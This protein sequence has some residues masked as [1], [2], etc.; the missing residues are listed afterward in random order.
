[1]RTISTAQA[2]ERFGELVDEL[3]IG[4]P[5]GVED[6]GSFFIEE[7]GKPVGL[8]VARESIVQLFQQQEEWMRNA[9]A[10]G[11]AALAAGDYVELKS[12][13][14]VHAFFEDIKRRGRERL[15]QEKQACRS[16]AE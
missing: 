1:M 13:E 7:D 2:R 3:R 8:V 11:E 16:A 12:E 6:D 10:E 4:T 14:D 15:A 9:I 5:F